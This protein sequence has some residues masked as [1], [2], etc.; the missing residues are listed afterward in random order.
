MPGTSAF[1][2]FLAVR[3]TLEDN[4]KGAELGRK[5]QLPFT[6]GKF[7]ILPM[8]EATWPGQS[9]STARAASYPD[10]FIRYTL[11]IQTCLHI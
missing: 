1:L 6:H 3:V 4:E 5:H 10:C 11:D 2:S 8:K 7:K 9:C